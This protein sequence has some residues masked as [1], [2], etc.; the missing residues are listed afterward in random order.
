MTAVFEKT[1][2]REGEVRSFQ[3]RPA[4]SAGWESSEADN[5]R[6]VQRQL[7]TDWHRVER[8]LARFRR[9]VA[10]LHRQGWRDAS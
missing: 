4:P 10:E 8:A 2:V 6:A 9:E 5:E 3:I 7:L 1:L